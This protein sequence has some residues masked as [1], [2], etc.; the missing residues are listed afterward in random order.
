M[1]ICI[2]FPFIRNR[3]KTYEVCMDYCDDVMKNNGDISSHPNGDSG[4]TKSVVPDGGRLVIN[5]VKRV[6]VLIKIMRKSFFYK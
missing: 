5:I 2:K 1:A 3:F 4:I 6:Y